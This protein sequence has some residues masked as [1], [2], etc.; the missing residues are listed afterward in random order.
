MRFPRCVPR[1]HALLRSVFAVTGIRDG[2]VSDTE[3]S[4][5]GIK[6]EVRGTLTGPN[7]GTLHVVTVWITLE[8]TGETRFV[9]L[10]PDREG[11][12]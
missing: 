5:Y 4:P 9:T 6:Y 10:F 3:T 1:R 12:R 2:Q 7:G 8:A 11:N